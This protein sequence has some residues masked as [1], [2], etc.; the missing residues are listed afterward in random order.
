MDLDL[1]L[2]LLNIGAGVNIESNPIAGYREWE[3]TKTSTGADK[4]LQERKK[5]LISHG[6]NMTD[7]T[8]TIINIEI[9]KHLVKNTPYLGPV[10]KA[11]VSFLKRHLFN[12]T[13]SL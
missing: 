9:F 3:G 1:W 12:D 8:M 10:C 13:L 5:L 7:K 2:R 4:L 11:L 6:V